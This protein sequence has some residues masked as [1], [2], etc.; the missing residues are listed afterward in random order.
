MEE[1]VKQNNPKMIPTIILFRSLDTNKSPDLQMPTLDLSL[2]GVDWRWWPETVRWVQAPEERRGESPGDYTQ[3][4]MMSTQGH[5][6]RRLHRHT[7]DSTL[8]TFSMMHTQEHGNMHSFNPFKILN[9]YL[10][11]LTNYIFF[12][13]NEIILWGK[14]R[15][16]LFQTHNWEFFLETCTCICKVIRKYVTL[17]LP[18]V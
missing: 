17:C 6:T 2:P 3:Y 12:R 10:V 18:P 11:F 15:C 13:Q 16:A 8:Y 9:S 14:K 7:G 4:Y 5:K 1:H